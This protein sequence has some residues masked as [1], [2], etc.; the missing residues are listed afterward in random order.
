MKKIGIVA[1]IIIAVIVIGIIYISASDNNTG[2]PAQ[3]K[4]GMILNGSCHDGSYSQAHYESMEKTAKELNLQVIYKENVPTDESSKAVMEVLID[5]G[6][7]IIICNSFSYEDYVVEMAEAN[8]DIYFL[9]ATGTKEGKNLTSFFGRMYQ[10]RYLS[11]VV[12]GMQTKTNKIGYIAAFP[13]PEV[14]RGINAFT[15]GARSVNPEVTV[16]V[17]WSNSWTDDTACRESTEALLEEND[18]DILTMHVDSIVPLEIADERGIY[19]IGYN[20]DNRDKY[21]DTYL[22]ADVWHWEA[23]YTPKIQEC[24]Q[25]DFNGCHEWLGINSDMMALAPL[26]DIV[27]D[28]IEAVVKKEEA[29][30]LTGTFD[31]FYGPIRDQEGNI[32]VNEGESMS[33][34]TMLNDF[35]WYVEGVVI[36]HEK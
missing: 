20:F 23:F 31:V 15:L 18:I 14:N 26:S 10:I 3:M 5:D 32:R 21:P 11:G 4:V 25:G 2:E 27:N 13:I 16:Y 30:L 28:D 24:M 36:E 9:H 29:K 19:T 12:A 33:D 8:P 6:C 1:V 17:E 22:T 34:A 35:D 7:E